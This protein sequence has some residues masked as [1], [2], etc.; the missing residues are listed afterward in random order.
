MRKI[1]LDVDALKVEEFST[2][3]GDEGERGTVRANAF[4]RWWEASCYESC[5]NI[6]DCLCLSEIGGCG[7]EP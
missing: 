6:A 7:T 2:T 1:K 3:A 4:T 5:T